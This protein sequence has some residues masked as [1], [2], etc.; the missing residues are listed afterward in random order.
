MKS[1][2]SRRIVPISLSQYAWLAV[3]GPAF[4]RLSGPVAQLFDRLLVKRCCHDHGSGTDNSDRLEWLLGTAVQST[5]PW[6]VR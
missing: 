6:D 3:L 2:H 5:L 1:K 4:S